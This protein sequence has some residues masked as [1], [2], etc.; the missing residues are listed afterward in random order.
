MDKLE[1]KIYELT[2]KMESH[3]ARFEERDKTI[4]NDLTDLKMDL[5]DIRSIITKVGI[6]LTSGVAGT[7]VTVL[8]R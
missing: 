2:S 3:V 8:L 7:L 4:F 1:T 5:K 6:L